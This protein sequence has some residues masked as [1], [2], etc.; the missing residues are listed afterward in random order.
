MSF[1]IRRLEFSQHRDWS[2]KTPEVQYRVFLDGF[3][4]DTFLTRERAEAYV[5]KRK[6]AACDRAALAVMGA[7]NE[8]IPGLF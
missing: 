4:Q 1:E 5:E 2:M 8:I 6:A 3:W 7:M